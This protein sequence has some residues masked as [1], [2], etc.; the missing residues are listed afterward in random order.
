MKNIIKLTLVAA[1]AVVFTACG[2][3]GGGSST[4][5]DT[6]QNIDKV[7]PMV[8]GVPTPIAAG[9]SIVDSSD[10][11]SIDIIVVGNVKT[12]TLT[13]GSASIQLP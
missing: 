8:K 6:L 5:I 3:G 2:G 7:V 13:A 10:D 12:A 4:A 11:A 1:T 9:Y